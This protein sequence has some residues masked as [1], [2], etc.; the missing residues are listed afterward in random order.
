MSI[1]IADEKI[2]AM[3]WSIVIGASLSGAVFYLR[4]RRIPNAITGPFLLA[5]L[6]QTTWIGGLSGKVN[7]VETFVL[8]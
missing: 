6:V 1:G 2:G 3:Q 8:T 4:T 5:G 7:P